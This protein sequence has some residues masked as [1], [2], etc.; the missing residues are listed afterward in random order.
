VSE[1]ALNNLRSS[2][3]SGPYYFYSSR[4]SKDSY[5]AKSW[6]LYLPYPEKE[7]SAWIQ[8]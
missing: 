8:A 1:D 5:W 6:N 2:L 7:M 3:G 4:Q